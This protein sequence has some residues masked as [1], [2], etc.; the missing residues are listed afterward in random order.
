MQIITLTS[1]WQTDDF[2]VSSIKGYLYSQCP[3]V[4][5]VD[6]T[7]RIEPH[8]YT[9]AAFVLKNAY[10]SFPVSTIHIV[11][12]N[13]ELTNEQPPVCILFGGHYFIGSANRVFNMLFDE[14]PEQIVKIDTLQY[15]N[16]LF[17]ELTVFAKAAAFLA[18][19]GIITNLGP[20]LNAKLK[21]GGFI[22]PYDQNSITGSVVYIDSYRNLITNIN[23][24][25]FYRVAQNRTFTIK[26]KSDSYTITKISNTYSDVDISDMVALFNSLGLLEIAMRNVKMADLMDIKINSPVT[27]TFK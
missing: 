16:S 2:Y 24:S 1:D 8:K 11:C 18:N 5:V 9:Q 10:N 17:P 21:P 26:V 15:K 4:N 6:I 27:I 3:N 22:A 13:S 23:K 25:L 12:I 20:L 19:G 14:N 7:H